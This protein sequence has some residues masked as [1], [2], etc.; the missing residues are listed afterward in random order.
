MKHKVIKAEMMGPW[1][2]AAAAYLAVFIFIPERSG[3]IGACAMS[4]I[5]AFCFI[6]QKNLILICIDHAQLFCSDIIDMIQIH[7]CIDACFEGVI[8][9]LQRLHVLFQALD[10]SDSR[11]DG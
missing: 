6:V 7:V 2:A 11:G 10:I 8:L 3:E 9:S 4:Y 1:K 5:L